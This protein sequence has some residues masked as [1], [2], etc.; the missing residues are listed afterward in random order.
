M[1]QRTQQFNSRYAPG[2][3]VSFATGV[4]VF[5]IRLAVCS[6]SQTRSYRFLF[7]QFRTGYSVFSFYFFFDICNFSFVEF[8]KVVSLWSCRVVK[9]MKKRWLELLIEIYCIT[10][11]MIFL[12]LWY[13]RVF[14]TAVESWL[15]WLSARLETWVQIPFQD[16]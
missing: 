1:R 6:T 2:N 4:C 11:I 7:V 14:E 13:Y 9:F 12:F 16:I 10:W 5:Y 3:I 15:L 8:F